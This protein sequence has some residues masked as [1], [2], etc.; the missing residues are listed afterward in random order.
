MVRAAQGINTID[1]AIQALTGGNCYVNI[2]TSNNPA[3]EI[4]GQ[5]IR[6]R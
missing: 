5:L 3:G 1:D 6:T 4:R 2:H